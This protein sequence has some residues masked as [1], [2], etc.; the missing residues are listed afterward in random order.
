MFLKDGVEFI[1]TGLLIGDTLILSD[2]HLGYEAALNKNGYLIPRHQFRE[3]TQ[4]IERIIDETMP[5]RIIINGD[6]K[7]EFG[8]INDQ[9]WRDTLKLIDFMGK[10]AEVILVKGNHDRLL[11]TIATRRDIK[12]RD[13][14]LQDDVFFVHGHELA[15]LPDDAETIVIGH[16]HPAIS[17]SDGLRVERYKC[18]L[19]GTYKGRTLIVQPAF[20]VMT[21]GSDVGSERLLSPYLENGV[22]DFEV[23]V[24]AKGEVYHFGTVQEVTEDLRTSRSSL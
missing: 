23:C 20:N 9:E 8:S 18:Y 13:T 22:A 1:D 6:I 5:S 24:V 19:I 17:I 21:E 2:I 4:K 15:D 7:H 14:Y 11:D 3:T 10:K 16:E 12:V